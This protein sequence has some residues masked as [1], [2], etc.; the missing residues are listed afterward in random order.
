M[1][2]IA[3][4]LE[5]HWVAIGNGSGDD[6]F[7]SPSEEVRALHSQNVI[8][9]ETLDD[10]NCL[11]L[12]GV[13][14]IGKTSELEKAAKRARERE[15]LVDFIRL[16]QLSG[17][18]ELR[19]RLFAL[20]SEI[21][22]RGTET[23]TIFLDGLDETLPQLPLFETEIIQS[24]RRLEQLRDGLPNLRLRI[25]C[26]AAEWPRSLQEQ[27]SAIWPGVKCQLLQ[28][29]QLT[30]Q[31]I[32]DAIAQVLS[33]EAQSRFLAQVNH[34]EAEPLAA[35][36]ITLKMLLNIFQHHF[37]LPNRQVELYRRALFASIE[38]AN[39]LRRTKRQVGTLDNQSKLM[40]IARIATAAMFSNSSEIWSGLQSDSI[41]A[42]SLVLS[43]IAGGYE[44]ALGT[45]F[46]VGEAELRES[47]STSLFIPIGE[48]RIAWA[49]QT[50]REFLAA[51]YLVE[52]E[53]TAEELL[54]L[55]RNESD[56]HIPTQLR[57]LAAWTASMR[58]DFFERLVAF[59]PDILLRSD[60]TAATPE[61]R[62]RL[63]TELLKRF[64]N[65]EIHDF[66]P[67]ARHRYDRL[68]HSG[69]SSQ[70]KSYIGEK[71]KSIVARRVAIDIAQANSLND[72]IPVLLEVALDNSD[73]LHI[74]SRAC[75]SL[76]EIREPVS[77]LRLKPLATLH[78]PEDVDDEV[79]GY[80]LR[81]VWPEQLT[82]TELFAALT[83]PKRENYFGA[84]WM[85]LR[86][87]E[88]P[89]L[90][91]E[92][93]IQAID[94][95]SAI[96][97]TPNAYSI[98]FNEL[99][100]QV[101]CRAWDES[102]LDGIVRDRFADFY[103]G[104]VRT[105]EVF[106]LGE[107]LKVLGEAYAK[108]EP[109]D[110]RAFTESVLLRLISPNGVDRLAWLALSQPF[111]LIATSDLSWVLQ[112]LF[113]AHERVIDDAVFE[114]VV[115]LTFAHNINELEPIWDA[116]NTRPALRNA[117]TKA[118]SVELSSQAAQW[119][120]EAFYRK[121]ETEHRAVLEKEK[122]LSE[123]EI[124][125][126]DIERGDSFQWWIANLLFFERHG[127]LGLPSEFQGNLT[128]SPVWGFLSVLQRD[129]FIAAARRFVA[130]NRVSFEWLGTNTF[131]RP[132]AAGYR[133]FRLL[134]SEH[135]RSLEEF[136]AHVWRS[137][138]SAIIGVPTNDDGNERDARKSIILKCY[139]HAGIRARR[140]V[141]VI[142]CRSHADHPIDDFLD[143][144]DLCFDTHLG[145][146]L[147][148]I[149][150]RLP[151]G[152][153]RASSIVRFLSRKQFEPVVQSAINCL[154]DEALR[155]D[156]F[157]KSEKELL[158]AAGA[159]IEDNTRSIWPLIDNMLERKSALLEHIIANSAASQFWNKNPF[160]TRL[161]EP[162]I[163]KLLIWLF[164]NYPERKPD[165]GG[166][167]GFMTDIDHIDSLRS[168][169]LRHLVNRGT[170]AAVSAIEQ[171][172][173]ALPELTWLKWQIVDARS[174]W[175]SKNWEKWKPSE[176][177]GFITA[178]RPLPPIRSKKDTL[179]AAA[180]D[181]VS[182]SDETLASPKNVN[183]APDETIVLPSE[184]IPTLTPITSYRILVVATEWSSAHGGLSTLN[185]ELCIAL[186]ELGHQVAC[187]VL[188][189]SGRD[190]DEA[191]GKHVRLIECPKL[192]GYKDT[193]RLLLYSQATAP[194]F[195][196]EIV[197][198]H[199]HA[200]GRE[201]YHIARQIYHIPLVLFVHTLP[202]EIELFKART[203]NS[204]E[205]AAA[206]ASI[207][208]QLCKDAQLVV[209]VGPR[210]YRHLQN[211]FRTTLVQLV[212]GLN[213]A[214]L[215]QAH[216]PVELRQ[217]LCLL[218]GR[219]ED[220]DLKGAQLACRAIQLMN[221]KWQWAAT[222]RPRLVIRGF[223]VDF[224]A[225][226]FSP[227]DKFKEY[228]FYRQ[229]SADAE[230]ITGDINSASV[231]IMPSKRE[232]FGL[233]ALEALAAGIPIL[234]SVESGVAA[235]L[236]SPEIFEILGKE[237]VA[238]CVAEVDGDEE[239]VC[240]D[241]AE[242]LR[243][244]LTD[245]KEAFGRAETIRTKLRDVLTWERA[246][247]QLSANFEKLF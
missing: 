184:R 228:V 58:L 186:A 187:L 35:R 15:E 206:K 220:G 229:F 123:L 24:L 140:I 68:Y 151:E 195:E 30:D 208:M 210:I 89:K 5:R 231:V 98:F 43:E 70:L 132:A 53:L 4:E 46:P 67:G 81:A 33:P 139:Q 222:F 116:A 177:I 236:Y 66:Q 50:F 203:G 230:D 144:I 28:L 63:V 128:K 136:P 104:L 56:S 62:G 227:L 105:G 135:P 147:A 223:S 131:H 216:D 181:I 12:L 163:A 101:L 143:K 3:F 79:K 149:V 196:P 18:E 111:P 60:V 134:Y 194:D 171:T 39:A 172:A 94:W 188:D 118:Y 199:D 125:L 138:A 190:I 55:L 207:Q 122:T 97:R 133:A 99:I 202:E 34:H 32:N 148:K 217:P 92:G 153:N 176:I 166:R 150:E 245:S 22:R 86:N 183:L 88:L 40:V 238:P 167:A 173:A 129:R 244:M 26:R 96:F 204:P 6:K 102:K 178:L 110:R 1:D 17:T 168:A 130:E 127:H 154:K 83:K 219:M 51:L 240:N 189:A 169:L 41:P 214:F 243:E 124:K 74:R 54:S 156:T 159:L 25:T 226:E 180:Q 192:I 73:D 161:Y 23:W 2:N 211:R 93:A 29:D 242:K 106:S 197:I 16:G 145:V 84:Y 37:E 47:L 117:L 137:W 160:Y 75:G 201:A 85:F 87:L 193:S 191:R 69:L 158:A 9:L 232:G 174:E 113:S 126:A 78:N 27:L 21:W 142:I 234:V 112:F 65:F 247:T 237:A 14:G 91:R 209:A 221:T 198:G 162:E 31:E 239:H 235:L 103:V 108:S 170:L 80:S 45:A 120:K 42:R 175:A 215:L 64:D 72:L 164:R 205:R 59:E 10:V 82:T 52:H 48:D 233:V 44:R 179:A 155:F 225:A 77:C 200:T 182:G 241:W 38:E 218:L 141:G 165:R 13:P 121:Q 19:A 246:A 7:V 224:P 20:N 119:Q 109:S 146:L 11:L 107:S 115:S 95:I 185:R 90:G 76:S 36:P 114:L 212:P 61:L 49:H 71:G 152:D 213:A 100:P 8:R 57:E 157:I